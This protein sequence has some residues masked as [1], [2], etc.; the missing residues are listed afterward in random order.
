MKK[1]VI[2]MFYSHESG[3]ASV[4]MLFVITLHRAK[5]VW[6]GCLVVAAHVL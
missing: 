4:F 5:H 1:S 6:C 2:A 3:V